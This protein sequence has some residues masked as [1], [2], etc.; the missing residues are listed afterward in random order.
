MCQNDNAGFNESQDVTELRRLNQATVEKFLGQEWQDQWKLF[1][2]DGIAGL[3]TP[4]TCRPEDFR[5]TGM[6][7]LR[8]YFEACAQVFPEWK[9][10]NAEIYQTQNPNQFWVECDG[11]GRMIFPAYPQ[12]TRHSCHFIL[13]FRMEKGKIKQWREFMNPCKEMMDVGIEVP[14]IKRPSRPEAV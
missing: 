6:E 1:T 5:I 7:N 4:E 13:S 14:R 9:F 3:E 12:A 2:E 8:P 10:T 11:A